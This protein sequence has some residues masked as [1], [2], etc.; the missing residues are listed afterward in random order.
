MTVSLLIILLYLCLLPVIS[1]MLA[2][3]PHKDLPPWAICLSLVATETSTLTI[4]SVPGV[5]YLKGYVFVGLAAGYLIGRMA[6]AIWFLPLHERGATS[7]YRYIG[8]RFGARL[9]KLLSGTFL[10]TRLVAEGVRLYAGMLPVSMLFASMGY[11]ISDL[12]L[13][14]LIVL[15]TLA[16]T[17]A[18]GLR[19]VVW[20]DS[21]Q[22]GLYLGGSIA[23]LGVIWSR[24]AMPPF[25]GAPV[26]SH[27]LPP[28]TDPFSIAGA[29]IGGAILSLASHG[30]DQLMLQR[31]LAAKTLNGARA[32]MIGSVF[33]VGGLFALLSCIGVSLR[34]LMPGQGSRPDAL[35]PHF[36][37]TLPPVLSGILIAG[38]LAATMGSLSSAMNAMAAATKADFLPRGPFSLRTLTAVWAVLLVLTALL[39]SRPS[40]SAVVFG[41][42]IASYSYGATLGVFL[43]AMIGHSRDERAAIAGFISAVGV[44]ALAS[45]VRIQGHTIAFPW[46]VPIGVMATF[47]GAGTFSALRRVGLKE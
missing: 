5:A 42:S 25:H 8:Q 33:V 10:V 34:D 22:L 13:L 1:I 37:L 31:C 28:F 18:G 11:A 15:L 21:L 23:C 12:S 7:I 45:Y 32:A 41:L 20:S 30:T 14:V 46:L 24:S 44:L 36:I 43:F 39:F 29:V 47:A 4:V 2:R 3:Q 9:Q 16:Y 40:G 19:A 27:G 35:F 6:V 26:F 17:L 38:I